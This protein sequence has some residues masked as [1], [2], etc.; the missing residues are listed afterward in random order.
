MRP[1]VPERAPRE[2]RDG[3]DKGF[4]ELLRQ[5]PCAADRCYTGDVQP[6]HQSHLAQRGKGQ[7]VEDRYCIPLSRARHDE[8]HRY[9]TR[10]HAA[11]LAEW[12]IDGA[13]LSNQL[14]RI[15]QHEPAD[16]R[17]HLMQYAVMAHG[18]TQ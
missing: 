13:A 18:G 3:D 5:C 6:H 7:K 2:K 15:H 8:L 4:L 1:K 9:G 12:G 16:R 10:R 17:L 14:W 11:V